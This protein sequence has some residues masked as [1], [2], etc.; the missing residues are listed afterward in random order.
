MLVFS[1]TSV[2]HT[3]SHVTV[4][5]APLPCEEEGNLFVISSDFCHWGAQFGDACS[6]ELL[7]VIVL[8]RRTALSMSSARLAGAWRALHVAVH[9]APRSSRRMSVRV[10]NLQQDIQ[11]NNRRETERER[12]AEREKQG[13]GQP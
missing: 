11:R 4:R 13:Y 8:C 2:L 5:S 12:E 3:V 10:P 6:V 1:P 9:V 7:V